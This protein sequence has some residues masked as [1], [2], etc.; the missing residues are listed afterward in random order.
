MGHFIIP[1]MIGT[2]GIIS[3]DIAEHGIINLEYLMAEIVKL[4]GDR[5]RLTAKI[6]GA[7]FSPTV[8]ISISNSNIRFLHDYFSYEKIP[9][10]KEDLG[11]KVRREI[12]FNPRTG[13]VYRKVL[14]HNNASSEFLR[15]EKEYIERAFRNKEI[16][17][18]VVLFD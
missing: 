10:D 17:T 2:E 16:K 5:K 8:K 14:S 3:S 15:L 1:G 18:H 12:I 7:A 6:F 11:G 9:V 13:E 4:G